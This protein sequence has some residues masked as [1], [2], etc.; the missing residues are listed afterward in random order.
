M[1]CCSPLVL[2]NKLILSSISCHQQASVGTWLPKLKHPL[3]F[4]FRHFFRDCLWVCVKESIR[5]C[6]GHGELVVLH[7]LW[8]D[9]SRDSRRSWSGANTSTC[10]TATASSS[11]STASTSK[12]SRLHLIPYCQTGTSG[13]LTCEVFGWRRFLEG[14]GFSAGWHITCGQNGWGWGAS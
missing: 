6:E 10:T 1:Y 9:S 13:S 8:S 14:G 11:T 7:S 4:G 3:I 12:M 2:P 5:G